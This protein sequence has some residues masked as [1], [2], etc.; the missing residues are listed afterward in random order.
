[1]ASE[2]DIVQNIVLQGAPEVAAALG[3]LGRAGSEAFEAISQSVEH[4]SLGGFVE[5]VAGLTLAV[6]GVTVA[7]FE[8]AEKSNEAVVGLEHLATQAGT[9]IEEISGMSLALT[10]AGANTGD[11]ESAFRRMAQRIETEWPAIQK[12][13]SEATITAEKDTIALAKAYQDVADA[14]IKAANQ[15]LSDA[16]SVKGAQLS[17]LEAKQKL[18]VAEGG[19]ADPQAQA[20]INLA[21]AKLAVNEAQVTLNEKLQKQAEDAALAPTKQ[22]EAE[23]KLQEAQQKAAEDQKNSIANLATYVDGLS[24]GISKSALPVV[25]DNVNN[26]IKG[27]IASTAGGVEGLK[28][29][30]GGLGELANGQAPQVKDVFLKLADVFKNSG[31]SALNMAVAVRLMGRGVGQDMVTAM[32]QGSAAIEAAAARMKSF[33]LVITEADGVIAKDFHT[34]L[35]TLKGDV[36][37][38]ADQFGLLLQPAFTA[39]FKLLTGAVEEN[40][41]KILD[42]GASI[43]ASILPAVTGLIKAVTG[44]DL[45]K[46]FGIDPSATE[47]VSAEILKVVAI[48][49]FLGTA[50]ATVFT[51]V[52]VPAFGIII[53]IAQQFATALNDIFGTNFNGLEVLITAWAVRSA[54]AFVGLGTVASAAL[55]PVLLA[56][57]GLAA[58]F[59]LVNT[60]LNAFQTKGLT[61]QIE[62]L[63]A[64]VKSGD[65]SVKDYAATLE[66]LRPQIEQVAPGETDKLLAD[67]GIKPVKAAADDASGALKGLQTAHEEALAAAKKLGDDG[68]KSIGQIPT[69]AKQGS[70][71]LKGLVPSQ[72]GQ[73]LDALKKKITDL[74]PG[75]HTTNPTDLTPGGLNIVPASSKEDVAA[76]KQ[77]I[78]TMVPAPGTSNLITYFDEAGR[79]VKVI[80][81]SAEA[82]AAASKAAAASQTGT[83][84]AAFGQK[85]IDEAKSV[86]VMNKSLQETGTFITQSGVKIIDVQRQ[87]Q[88]AKD[89]AAGLANAVKSSTDAASAGNTASPQQK[90]NDLFKDV[91]TQ[92]AQGKIDQFFGD[93]DAKAQTAQQQIDN[94]FKN[95]NTSGIDLSSIGS[96]IADAV[97]SG[98]NT[99]SGALSGLGDTLASGLNSAIDG[100]TSKLSGLGDSIASGLNSAVNEIG[101]AL[102]GLGGLL[103][104]LVSK[105]ASI[106]SAVASAV[107]SAATA[108]SGNLG[109]PSFSDGGGG[110]GGF[111]MGG[112]VYGPGTGTSDSILAFLSNNEFVVR[113]DGSN[114]WQA[115]RHFRVPGFA[116]GGLVA[117]GASSLGRAVASRTLN[118]TIDGHK[119]HGLTAPENVAQS[120]ERFSVFRQVT[121]GGTA[122]RWKR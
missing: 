23:L 33:G 89:A 3:A 1:M 62:V 16:N 109:D 58:G 68:S 100:I 74:T 32:S 52:I 28:S 10:Q 71:A 111:A 27:L 25:N 39:F 118:L 13:A 2:D 81:N 46:A 38:V 115:L 53:T 99:A 73:D 65:L 80:Q 29:L 77:M 116:G 43:V 18:N 61:Q 63:Q 76:I 6:G 47:A 22:L 64:A 70:D 40:R 113:A 94:L 30:E 49:K 51:E 9:S 105:A 97:N 119:F 84:T 103:D 108:G 82:I 110:T 78:A 88:L 20:D 19:A 101:G 121:S 117:A 14:S 5:L 48:F 59:T 4:A 42:W 79:Q 107:S 26:I 50:I 7:L 93:V 17:L 98:I 96:R 8:W 54:L 92:T 106:A 24:K 72:T 11:L 69:T 67:V 86:D 36:G 91:D 44:V 120:L 34:A 114:L 45:S 21:R 66:K 35:N 60:V 57:A 112:P 55:A 41:Q 31:D 37:V 87:L 75:Q 102:S 12:A 95:I 15:E 83:V 104:G 90:I 85:F 56:L 122:P